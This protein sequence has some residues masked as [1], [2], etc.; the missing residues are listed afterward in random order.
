MI[1]RAPLPTLGLVS[2]LAVVTGCS[3]TRFD[4]AVDLLSLHY[5]HAPD[6]DDG[7]S[8][9]AD[10]TVL[11]SMFGK[12][13]IGNHVVAVSG[14]Y[15]LNASTFNDSSDAV[16]DVVFGADGWLNA[17][18]DPAG[19]AQQLVQRFQ[20]VIGAGGDIWIKEGGQSDLT[21]RVIRQLREQT[22]NLETTRRIHVVQHSDWNERQTTPADLAY[23]QQRT[24]YIRIPDANVHLN[25]EHGNAQ[26]E[27]AAVSHPV[28]G[29]LWRAAFAYYSPRE[30]LDF[31][32]TGELLHLLGVG[33]LDFDGFRQRFLMN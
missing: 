29:D 24:N 27:T 14:A 26:F 30:R 18:V 32:D 20:Q 19:V 33:Q 5:D 22:P 25:R 21:A 13:W 10:I 15:G 9:A 1:R 17:H 6:K 23:V 16:M 31:S 4:P 8:A 28:F 11:E 12:Q 3:Q 2:L 7:Q